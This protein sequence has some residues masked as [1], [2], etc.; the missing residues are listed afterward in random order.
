M[1][2]INWDYHQSHNSIDLRN[3]EAVKSMWNSLKES[4][5]KPRLVVH[6]VSVKFKPEGKVYDYLALHTYE[7][8]STAK[9]L[10]G[11]GP[12]SVFVIGTD[13]HPYNNS[14]CYQYLVED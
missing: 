12:E 1:I 5:C 2:T 14:L 3:K 13:I 4:G 8:A 9:I 6:V 11:Q 10:G 7:P